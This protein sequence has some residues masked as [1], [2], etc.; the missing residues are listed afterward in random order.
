MVRFP[1]EMKLAI[2][3]KYNYQ[4]SILW[5]RGE[6]NSRLSNANAALCHL[7]TGPF[8]ASSQIA[9]KPIAHNYKENG[10]NFKP[11]TLYYIP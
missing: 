8:V 1:K 6:S 9:A 10:N 3:Y 7:T 11:D 4:K 2:L 5:T